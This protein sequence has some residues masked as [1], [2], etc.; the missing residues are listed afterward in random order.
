MTNTSLSRNC[1]TNPTGK[2]TAEAKAHISEDDRDRLSAL[3]VINGQNV[4]EYLRDLI[5]EHLYGHLWK[6]RLAQE[7]KRGG[8]GMGP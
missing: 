4:S 1:S 7:R 5:Q 8:D 3:A 6:M 2:A